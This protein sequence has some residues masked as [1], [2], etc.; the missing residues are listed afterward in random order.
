MRVHCGHVPRSQ[1]NFSNPQP[2]EPNPPTVTDQKK[3]GRRTVQGTLREELRIKITFVLIVEDR[4]NQSSVH[5]L[6]L[7]R[8]S[9]HQNNSAD[10]LS[11]LTFLLSYKVFEALRVTDVVRSRYVIGCEKDSNEA[12][13]I[14]VVHT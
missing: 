2:V 1:A 14:R 6:A 7:V 11:Y 12:Q 9:V 4:S 5:C 10:V 3:C 8:S 13:K